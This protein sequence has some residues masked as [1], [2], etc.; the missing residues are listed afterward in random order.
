MVSVAA[1]GPK[2]PGSNTSWF[3]SQIQIKNW[4]SKIVQDCGTL[5]STVTLVGGE[6]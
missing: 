5:A 4:V 1:F 3:A 2:D 6:K